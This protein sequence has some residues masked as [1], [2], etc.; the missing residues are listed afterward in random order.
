[1]RIEPNN[2]GD[3]DKRE[4][5]IDMGTIGS[6]KINQHVARTQSSLLLFSHPLF[7]ICASSSLRFG[8]E[9][10]FPVVED[11][12][13]NGKGRGKMSGIRRFWHGVKLRNN[14]L[15]AWRV[16]DVLLANGA[17]RPSVVRRNK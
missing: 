15:D 14:K 5:E 7:H 3:G 17:R 16:W 4:N 11:I 8:Q 2:R 12:V 13:A 10:K 1:M 6:I 9:R